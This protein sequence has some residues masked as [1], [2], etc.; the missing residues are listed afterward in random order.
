MVGIG[1]TNIRH[2]LTKPLLFLAP[3]LILYVLFVVKP[4]FQSLYFS[5][6]RWN[7]ISKD[8][9]FTGLENWKTILFEDR[10]F[11]WALRNTIIWTVCALTI[12]VSIGLLLATLLN[13]DIKGRLVFRGILYFPHILSTI[14]ISMVWGWIY[15]PQLGLI[16]S[17]LQLVGLGHFARGWLSDPI[18]ALPA[19]FAIAVWSSTGY[20]MMIFLS[21]LQAIPREMYEAAAIDGAGSSQQFFKI[22][23]PLLRE[24]FIVL[25]ATTLIGSFKLFDIVFATTQG[26]PAQR[27]EVLATWM[28]HWTYAVNDV[29]K[30]AVI[31]WIMV[32]MVMVIAVPYISYLTRKSNY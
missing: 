32:L 25:F 4:G 5:F 17:T 18:L 9:V 26:G 14:V 28:Y 27:T 16:N 1:G 7:G 6:F 10:Y 24:T 19:V 13:R 11:Y 30:G 29:G 23:I 15:H 22:T 20:F 12:P 31:S 3:A 2:R 8:M 21:G